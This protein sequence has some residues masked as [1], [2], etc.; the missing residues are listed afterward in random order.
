M[1]TF[2]TSEA[3]GSQIVFNRVPHPAYQDRI[4]SGKPAGIGWSDLGQRVPKG[5]GLHRMLGTLWGT[6]S[7]FRN[8]T[9]EALTDY[10]VGVAAIDG[11]NDGVIGRG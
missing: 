6:D 9:V 10:G 1:N 7:H 3:S 11:A 8:P 2:S 5:V 4:I